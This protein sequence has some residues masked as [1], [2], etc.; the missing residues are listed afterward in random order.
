[1]ACHIPIWVK[2]TTLRSSLKPFSNSGTFDQTDSVA[3]VEGGWASELASTLRGG[4]MTCLAMRVRYT[5]SVQYQYCFNLSPVFSDCPQK[6]EV[7]IPEFKAAGSLKDWAQLVPT[8]TVRAYADAP[9]PTP[10]PT[11][12][13][14]PLPTNTPIPTVAPTATP[15]PLL[16]EFP[17]ERIL[18]V[19]KLDDTTEIW[20]DG[21]PYSIARLLHRYR[22]RPFHKRY[23]RGWR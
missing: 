15:H 14:E 7:T 9:T 11:A 22:G 4:S 10:M 21:E 19:G 1:M 2:K 20:Q 6:D 3:M 16:L 8:K 17:K 18:P 13:A 5:R 12:T 23:G